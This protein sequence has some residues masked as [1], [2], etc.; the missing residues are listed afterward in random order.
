MFQKRL[1]LIVVLNFG[2]LLI[3]HA[4][5]VAPFILNIG[6]GT[7]S[8]ILGNQNQ[9]IFNLPY[10]NGDYAALDWSIGESASI[11]SF[12]V[13]GFSLNTGVLQPSS[14]IVTDIIESGPAIFGAEI[15]IGPNPTQNQIH[16]KGNFKESGL[17]SFQLM[18]SK[19]N[20]LMQMNAGKVFNIFEQKIQLYNYVS[21]ILYLRVGFMSSNGKFRTGM[22][23]IIKL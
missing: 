16:V 5:N 21:G 3:L 18:D 7:A 15:M 8:T 2:Y 9:T 14:T 10:I 6:G 20:F 4:Q 19:S 17:L 22:Y 11:A 23:K 13:P 1:I 12:V